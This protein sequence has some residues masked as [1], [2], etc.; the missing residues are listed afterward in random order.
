ME[1]GFYIHVIIFMYLFPRPMVSRWILEKIFFIDFYDQFNKNE[2][3]YLNDKVS[4]CLEY[5]TMAHLIKREYG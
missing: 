3:I 1:N 5:R 2:N 4:L